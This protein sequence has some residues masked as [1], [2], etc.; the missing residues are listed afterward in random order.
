MLS[1]DFSTP[2]KQNSAKISDRKANV[3]SCIAVVVAVVVDVVAVIV[4]AVLEEHT[5]QGSIALAST[6]CLEEFCVRA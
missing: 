6:A 5:T 3:S 2:E 4:A 1:H